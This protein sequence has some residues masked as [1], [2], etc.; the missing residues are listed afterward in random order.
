MQ[1]KRTRALDSRGRPVPGLYVRD[2]RFIT[3]YMLDGRWMMRTLLADTLTEARRERES[4]L[5]GLREG[6]VARRRLSRS[7]TRS[8]SIKQH[9]TCQTAHASMSAGS[10]SSTSPT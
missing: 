1:G 9:A 4:L 6:R 5:A 10:S 3:G 7:A 2:G 8:M